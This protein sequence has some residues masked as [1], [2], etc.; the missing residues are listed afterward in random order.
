MTDSSRFR[1]WTKP[2][3]V[4]PGEAASGPAS[5]D[6]TLDAISGHY[7]LFQLKAGHRFSTD[8]L[9][10]AWYGTTHAP[11]AGCVLELGSGIGTVGM[12]AAW[13]WPEAR[14]VTVE[15]QEE[16]VRL[17]RKSH[18]YNGLGA[19]YEIR[20]GDFR[21]LCHDERFD[22]VLGSP[23]YF[24][25]GTGPTADHPQKIACRFELRG[26]IFDYC[27]AAARHLAPGGN[28]ACVFPV[29]PPHQEERALAAAR[30]AGLVIV[31]MRPVALKEGDAPLLAVFLMALRADLPEGHAGFREPELVIRKRDGS[32]HPEYQAVKL[33]IGFPP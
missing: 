20:H 6:E 28:F 13:R 17:A 32:V 23:P 30:E 8:D 9:L 4:P 31:R 29:S 14:F 25:E 18:L 27:R 21:E 15:A 11:R 16:S 33:S 19:R 10:V 22:L 3:P 24:P 2:G 1:G 7:R 5:P 26:S 12:I